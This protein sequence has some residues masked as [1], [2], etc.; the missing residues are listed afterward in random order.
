MPSLSE[1][2]AQ[3]NRGLNSSVFGPEY[4]SKAFNAANTGTADAIYT[5][6]S[7]DNVFTSTFGR[8]V[9][10]SLN[11]Q[12]RFFNAIPRTVFGNT[13]GWRVRTDRGTQRSR[14]ITETGSLPDID[15][16]NLETISSLP[17]IVSTSFGASVKAMYTAQLEGGVGDVL[18]LENENAQLDHIKELNQEL[19]LPNTVA[20][21]AAGS[22]AT[23]ANVTAGTDLRIGDTIQLVDAGAATANNV[24]ISAISGTDVTLGTMSGTPAAGTS[25]VADN[26]SVTAR[27]GLTSIDDIVQIINSASQGNAGVQSMGS[28]Y[29]L[30]VSTASSKQRTSGSWNAAAAV[31]GNSGVGRDLSLNLL[32][33]CIQAIRTNGGEPKLILMGH[34]QYFKLERLLNSQQRYMGQEEYQVGVGSEKT[35]P[36]TRTGLVL[37]TYQGIPIL[38]D[39][40]TTKSEAASGGSKLGSNIYVLDTDY[41]EIAVAQPT[42]Y[43]ENRDYFAAD[44]LVVRGLLYTMA[45]FRAYRFDVHAKIQDLST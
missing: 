3:S 37:A 32:D 41:L 29:D 43:I 10:Q 31:K 20:N 27:A 15:V 39:A 9:W 13:V 8:K 26:L 14:P 24:A 38:P 7:A 5:T 25:T 11:N 18:A 22:G 19:L 33:D 12:T 17:K 28:A 30:T 40:D 44:A 16:S 6:T 36:G 35:F 1:Y 34:D 21:I 23:D 4:L 2:I 45:E 42:Q